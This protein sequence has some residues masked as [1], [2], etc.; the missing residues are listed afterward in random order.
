[1]KPALQDRLPVTLKAKNAG[2]T[3]MTACIG[4]AVSITDMNMEADSSSAASI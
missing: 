2:T 3:A 4:D 1:M